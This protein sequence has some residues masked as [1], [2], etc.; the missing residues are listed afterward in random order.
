MNEWYQVIRFPRLHQGGNLRWIRGSVDA[1][2]GVCN[3]LRFSFGVCIVLDLIEWEHCNAPSTFL[4]LGPY[5]SLPLHLT[6]ILGILR[7]DIDYLFEGLALLGNREEPLEIHLVA[8]HT[9]YLAVVDD[10]FDFGFGPV[11]HDAHRDEVIEDACEVC[12][13]PFGFVGH[14]YTHEG[15]FGETQEVL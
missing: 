7:F 14:A 9:G 6:Q 10:V 12:V 15:T 4:P 11:G 3:K 1:Y 8:H 5:D 2:T 13:N